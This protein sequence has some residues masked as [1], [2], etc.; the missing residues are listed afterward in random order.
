MPLTYGGIIL[1]KTTFGGVVDKGKDPLTKMR[2]S[3]LLG[4]RYL[5]ER[6][7]L[8]RIPSLKQTHIP[9]LRGYKTNSG[10]MLLGVVGTKELGSNHFP[11]SGALRIVTSSPYWDGRGLTT[12]GSQSE[13]KYTTTK[14]PL[15]QVEPPGPPPLANLG[16]SI[17]SNMVLWVG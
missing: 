9:A 2:V 1:L 5:K 12:I 10:D 4:A 16:L 8:G 11:C 7:H 14:Y 13:C 3:I 15:S 6:T 17:Q